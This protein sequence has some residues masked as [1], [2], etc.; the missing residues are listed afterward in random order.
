MLLW[1]VVL[2][3]ARM[4]KC[5]EICQLGSA[6]FRQCKAEATLTHGKIMALENGQPRNTQPWTKE[7]HRGCGSSSS[8]PCQ[9]PKGQGWPLVCPQRHF[10]CIPYSK[11]SIKAVWMSV[12]TQGN[13]P[14]P[15]FFQLGTF[16]RA[17]FWVTSLE[18]GGAINPLASLPAYVCF[19][20]CPLCV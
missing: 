2:T 5:P 15:A 19:L 10:V 13:A 7:C 4:S 20:R 18:S 11:H 8:T 6:V 16:E 9:T 1:P 3:P 17:A 12:P 14:P